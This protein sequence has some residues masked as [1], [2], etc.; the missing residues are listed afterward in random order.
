[1]N[2]TVL[3]FHGGHGARRGDAVVVGGVTMVVARV[4]S[5]TTLV[6]REPRWYERAWWRM[7]AVAA[8]V[9]RRPS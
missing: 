6:L 5:E 3:T 8:K 4:T 2:G 7:K 1:V 9:L